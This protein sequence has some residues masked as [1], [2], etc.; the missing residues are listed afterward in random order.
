MI[1]EQTGGKTAAEPYAP[2]RD[3]QFVSQHLA[4]LRDWLSDPARVGALAPSGRSLAKLITSGISHETGP[5]LELGPGTG[6]FTQALLEQGVA[7]SNLTLVEYGSDF[8]RL[9]D[10]RFPDVRVLWMD[11]ARLAQHSLYVGAPVGAVVS[12]LP[13]LAMSPRKVTMILAGA[14]QLLR[15]GGY[16]VQFT[17]GP[18]CPVPRPVLDRLGLKATLVGRTLRNIPPASVYRIT[19]RRPPSSTFMGSLRAGATASPPA[20]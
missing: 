11:A 12:G 20:S 9:L 5:V 13:L 7:P 17:Y 10:A 4:F 1:V 16:F 15:P 2:R 8:A 6:A 19:R 14:F 18:V 3:T